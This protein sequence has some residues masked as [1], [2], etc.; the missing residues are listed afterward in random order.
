MT[1]EQND[2]VKSKGPFAYKYWISFEIRNTQTDRSR[3]FNNTVFLTR[4]PKDEADIFAIEEMLKGKWVNA[5]IDNVNV[6]KE[7][8]AVTILAWPH[9]LGKIEMEKLAAQAVSLA[10]QTS[11]RNPPPKPKKQVQL[12]L[13]QG[14]KNE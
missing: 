11:E 10:K 6:N 4:K 3:R 1:S 5:K 8:M 7:N 9:L 13:I 14:G 12:T 2:K